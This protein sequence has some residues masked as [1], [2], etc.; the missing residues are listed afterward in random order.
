[1]DTIIND[2]PRRTAFA[3]QQQG[4]LIYTLASCGVHNFASLVGLEVRRAERENV[5]HIWRGPRDNLENKILWQ[6]AE[7]RRIRHRGVAMLILRRGTVPAPIDA[8]A[9]RLRDGGA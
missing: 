1:M 7:A 2:A 9:L 5:G 6:I 8:D 4:A 3:P